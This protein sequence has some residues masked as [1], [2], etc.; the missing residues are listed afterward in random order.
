MTQTELSAFF[1]EKNIE[2]DKDLD[3]QAII[4]V[5]SMDRILYL[6]NS[7]WQKRI[8]VFR[9]DKRAYFSYR[10]NY[11]IPLPNQKPDM[12]CAHRRK[13]AAELGLRQKDGHFFHMFNGYGCSDAISN[14]KLDD[15]LFV[16][17]EETFETGKIRFLVTDF[18]T[19]KKSELKWNN[20]VDSPTGK[21]KDPQKI[22]PITK[23]E[24]VG[25]MDKIKLIR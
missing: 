2:I 7:Y 8:G 25:S 3:T 20:W 1:S 23:F 17:V 21:I 6:L 9:K 18:G 4:S 16:I 19:V 14:T 10:L 15:D 5:I 24:E 13:K 22:I 11:S 12:P